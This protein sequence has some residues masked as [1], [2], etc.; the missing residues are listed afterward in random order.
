[1]LYGAQLPHFLYAEAASTAVYVMNRTPTR[2]Q[3]KT[4]YELWTGKPAQSVVDVEPFQW[5]IWNHVTQDLQRNWEPN[6]IKRHLV[7][8]EERNQYRAYCNHSIIITRDVHFLPSAPEVALYPPVAIIK[9]DDEEDLGAALK[10]SK[11]DS[12]AGTMPPAES[13]RSQDN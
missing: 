11:A 7:D 13:N 3:M 5:E 9:D 10:S 2:S 1:M 12:H 4:P 8:Y 6:A